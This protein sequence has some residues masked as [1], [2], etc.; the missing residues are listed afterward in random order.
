M[1]II[2]IGVFPLSSR[3]NGSIS[4][5]KHNYYALVHFNIIGK[6]NSKIY[7]TKRETIN[8][9]ESI[10]HTIGEKTMVKN[11]TIKIACSKPSIINLV[12]ESKT[13]PVYI[14]NS[15]DVTISLD[16]N[17]AKP[18]IGFE[19]SHVGVDRYLG[20]KKNMLDSLVPPLKKF[21][22]LP[23]KDFNAIN[24][25]IEYKILKLRDEYISVKSEAQFKL[26]DDADVSALIIIH[27]LLYQDYHEYFTKEKIQTN[28]SFKSINGLPAFINNPFGLISQNYVDLLSMYLDKSTREDTR[29]KGLSIKEED[30]LYL[31]KKFVLCGSLF[32]NKKVSDFFSSKTLLGYLNFGFTDAVT[33]KLVE[34]KKSYPGSTYLKFPIERINALKKLRSGQIAPNI[35]FENIDGKKISLDSFKGRIVFLDIWSVGCHHSLQELPILDKIIN[36]LEPTGKVAFL[37]VNIDDSRQE[38]ALH[39]RDTPIS[40]I[41]V[42]APGDKS[43]FETEYFINSLPRYILIDS[44]GKMIDAFAER[45]SSPKFMERLKELINQAK[46]M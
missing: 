38:L 46:P 43:K 12:Y 1:F 4:A 31:N 44:H 19:G 23:I 39:L 7:F 27:K 20:V 37:N 17:T 5:P 24:D 40:G 15:T 42:V 16:I 34:A 26:L 8:G 45:P 13:F 2:L 30:L 32:Q 41:N 10:I 35:W 6:Q 21:Y 9:E 18:Q 11:N 25:S 29:S 22:P 36:Q 33:G 28:Y 14:D 3:L